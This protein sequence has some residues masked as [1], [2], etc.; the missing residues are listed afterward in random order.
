VIGLS[1]NI[2][3]ICSMHPSALAAKRN[4]KPVEGSIMKAKIPAN[5]REQERT[6]SGRVTVAGAR[7]FQGIRPPSLYKGSAFVD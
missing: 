7:R 4:F 3:G 2:K 1:T 6:A 5:A